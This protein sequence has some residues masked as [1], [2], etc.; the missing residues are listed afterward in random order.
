M[1]GHVYK[2]SLIGYS[3]SELDVVLSTPEVVS[4][5]SSNCFWFQARLALS[6]MMSEK[7]VIGL[8]ESPI[9]SSL[10]LLWMRMILAIFQLLEIV[11][12]KRWRTLIR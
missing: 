8:P 12:S 1:R 4:N 10:P 11:F 2:S 7:S 9:S 5:L 3:I 6:V